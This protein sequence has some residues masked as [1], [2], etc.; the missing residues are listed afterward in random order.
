[1]A[2]EACRMIMLGGTVPKNPL[3]SYSKPPVD[4]S[5]SSSAHPSAL[6]SPVQRHAPPLVI[7]NPLVQIEAMEEATEM[8][9]M[10]PM[11]GA[12]EQWPEDHHTISDYPFVSVFCPTNVPQ[13]TPPF[14][15]SLHLPS[16]HDATFG[17]YSDDLMQGGSPQEVWPAPGSTHS[18]N[19]SHMPAAML[20][21][22]SNQMNQAPICQQNIW[23]QHTA[24]PIHHPPDYGPY[25][26]QYYTH[27]N[28]PSEFVSYRWKYQAMHSMTILNSVIFFFMLFSVVSQSI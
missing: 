28:Y 13:N 8:G 17:A 3:L 26:Q 15:P 20:N 14:S 27:Y 25:N 6:P 21:S 9:Y 4:I 16:R 18:T 1:M 5:A 22:A 2:E 11:D 12:G 24:P 23:N 10:E 19:S 7:K